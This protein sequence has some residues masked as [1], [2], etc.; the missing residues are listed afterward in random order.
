[1]AN[2]RNGNTFYIDSSSSAGTAASFLSDKNI[3]VTGI[4]MFSGTATDTVKIYDKSASS[5][6]AGSLKISLMSGTAKDAHQFR[7]ADAPI[8]FPNGIWVTISGTPEVTL[9][10]QN[11]GA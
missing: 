4:I 11:A 8:V 5:D 7:F 9:I 2:V 10:L 3:K 6:A 1:M